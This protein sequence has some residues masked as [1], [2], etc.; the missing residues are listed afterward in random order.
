MVLLERLSSNNFENFKN[1]NLERFSKENYD[2]NFFEYYENEKFFLKIFLKKFVKLFIYRKEVIG[3]IWYEIPV[4]MPV[5]VW[6]LYIKPEYIDLLSPEILKSFNNTILSYETCNDEDTNRMLINLGFKKVKPSLLMNIELSNYNKTAQVALLKNSLEH[7]SNVINSLNNLYNGNIRNIN[8][9]TEK[10]LLDRDEEL[11][12]KIQN[13]VF[14]A[15]T[16][17]PLEVE[18]IQNDIEQDY[19]MEDLSLFIKLN[20]IAIGYGQ[21]IFNRDMYTVVN[22]GILKE[23]RGYGFG[24]ILLNELI[25][26]AKKM[27]INELFIRVEENNYSALKLYNWIGFKSKSIINKW[28]R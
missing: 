27:Q 11:R 22:F 8:I 2:K 21:I 4:E 16:R 9:T 19:Y 23:F 14:S 26:A 25:N 1:L 10:V 5:R 17:I 12:C 13:S 6:S 15:T 7:N 3:Y 18:D 20:N 24:K 28:E